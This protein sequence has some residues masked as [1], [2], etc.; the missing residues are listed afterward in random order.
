[1]DFSEYRMRDGGIGGACSTH[2]N[3]EKCL[4]NVCC[5]N[6]KEKPVERPRNRREG[7]V[8]LIVII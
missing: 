4:E 5:K 1:M 8:K 7:N 6:R 2:Y 3:D